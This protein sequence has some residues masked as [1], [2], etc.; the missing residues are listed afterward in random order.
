VRNLASFSCS[1]KF[2]HPRNLDY[3]TFGPTI[4]IQSLYWAS[5]AQD[6]PHVLWST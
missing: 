5:G 1:L 6:G 4:R 2:E 3:F